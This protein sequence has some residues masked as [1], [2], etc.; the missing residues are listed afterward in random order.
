MMDN[1]DLEDRLIFLEEVI[2]ILIADKLG[3][4]LTQKEEDMMDELFNLRY[5]NIY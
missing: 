3:E 5:W 4:E 2:S 1:M